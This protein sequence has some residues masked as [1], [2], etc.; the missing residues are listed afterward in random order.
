M[1]LFSIRTTR[2]ALTALILLS[3]VSAVAESSTGS[4]WQA[5]TTGK[6]DLAARYRYEWVDDKVNSLPEANAHTQRIALGYRTGS[7]H[8]VSLYT[9]LEQVVALQEHYSDG[10]TNGKPYDTV[11]DPEGT[12]LNQGYINYTGLP[13]TQL[14]YGRQVITY[15]KA[16]MH[17]FIGTVQWRQNWQTFDGVTLTNRSLPDTT[18]HLGYIHNVNRIFGEDHPTQDNKHLNGYLVNAQYR[19][20]AH[21]RLEGYAYL[22]DY[23]R[24]D[25]FSVS[26][27]TYGLRASGKHALGDRTAALYALEVANQQD[28]QS[29]FA[30]NNNYYLG[31]LGVNRRLTRL[32][33]A[34]TVKLSYEV[35][36]GDAGSTR[37]PPGGASFLTPLATGHAYQG[38]ADRFL[39]TP[40]AGIEDAYITLGA[41]ALGARFVAVYHDFSANDRG[42]DYGNELDLLATKTFLKRYTLGLKYASYEADG[43][44]GNLGAPR[45][46]VDKFWLFTQVAY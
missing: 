5:A 33:D 28:Y 29:P 36:E 8:D 16:P 15:R 41:K 26:S 3:G 7:F 35:L 10:G 37:G 25:A 21:T 32:L 30:F 31:E 9:Q 22:L 46:D 11:V 20:F 6:F 19:G 17:R 4:P 45:A 34:I 27:Q 2:P 24:P 40:A 43:N 39:R 12:E 38:W 13:D 18:I 1:A 23:D 14:R 42:F 44:A